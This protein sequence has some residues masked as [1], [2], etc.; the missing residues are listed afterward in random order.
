MF[1]RPKNRT[2]VCGCGAGAVAA[3]AATVAAAA[4]G[5]IAGT[6]ENHKK[7]KQIGTN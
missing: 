1:L 6:S 7:S 3:A 4:R 5:Q 2:P